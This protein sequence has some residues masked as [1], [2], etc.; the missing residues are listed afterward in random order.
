MSFIWETCEIFN[1]IV[2][3]IKHVESKHEWRSTL[4]ITF[5]KT[6]Y[7]TAYTA[8]TVWKCFMKEIIKNLLRLD[9]PFPEKTL[10]HYHTWIIV[11]SITSS[12]RFAV[13]YFF[14][15]F[16]K[17][18]RWHSRISSTVTHQFIDPLLPKFLLLF[19]QQFSKS[20]C[21]LGIYLYDRSA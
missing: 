17:K 9:W 10:F 11:I 14:K 4:I 20:M 13:C 8:T 2:K 12:L 3:F 5:N 16:L 1:I 18:L 15:G 7:L 6:I 21:Y 19:A